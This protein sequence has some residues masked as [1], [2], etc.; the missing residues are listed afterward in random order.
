MEIP[1]PSLAY[2]DHHVDTN[3]WRVQA[4]DMSRSDLCHTRNRRQDG[5]GDDYL[6]GRDRS[7]DR[8]RL[9]RL[10]YWRVL[11][12]SDSRGLPPSMFGRV[13]TSTKSLEAR[14]RPT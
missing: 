2:R 4:A 13:P 9:E 10:K 8:K 5:Q 6:V 12:S 14:K 7:P 1:I 3:W 11:N